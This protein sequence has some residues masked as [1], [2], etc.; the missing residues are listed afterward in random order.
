VLFYAVHLYPEI[1]IALFSLYIFRMLSRKDR[2]ASQQIFFLGFVLSLFIWFGLKYNMIFFPLLGVSVFYLLKEH[3]ARKKVLFFL[4]SPA[5]SLGLFYL[6]I[7]QLYG[8]FSPF[9]IYEGVMTPEKVTAFREMMVQIPVL[10]RIETFLDY[11]LDQRDGLLLYS[12]FFLFAFLGMVECFRK[13]RRELIILLLLILPFILNYAFFSHRQ[14]YSPQGRILA[15]LIWAGGIFIGYFLIYNRKKLYSSLF[16]ICSILSL[17]FPLVLLSNPSFLYQPT[18]HEF[19]HRAGDLFVF[20]GNMHIFLPNILPSFIKIDNLGYLPN[21][22]WLLALAG[23]ILGYIFIKKSARQIRDL[24][25][26]FLTILFVF[27]FLL[28]AAFPRPA[29]YPTKTF[30]FSGQKAMGFYLSPMGEGVVAKKMAELHL[31]KEKEYRILFSSRTELERINIRFGSEKGEYS[32]RFSLFDLPVYEGTS[33]YEIKILEV[34]PEAFYPFRNL[35]LYEINL[36][37]DQ[38]S[39]ESM[40]VDPFFFQVVPLK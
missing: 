39:S 22:F 8:S 33:S 14:G 32:L 23:F 6:Y 24:W 4:V 38:I 5:L 3:K 26:V 31:H 18:T 9:S 27:L 13:A 35:F 21:Y 28:W 10:L 34:T 11:F 29:L 17:F 16:V 30:Q 1:P 40:L 36:E 12:P 2:L 25:P 19:T 15:P 20:L 37:L 7:N